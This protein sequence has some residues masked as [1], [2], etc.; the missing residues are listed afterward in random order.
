MRCLALASFC[1]FG[2]ISASFAGDIATPFSLTQQ[3]ALSGFPGY[4]A[5]RYYN[6]PNIPATYGSTATVIANRPLFLPMVFPETVTISSISAK[7]STVSSGG[8]FAFAIYAADPTTKKPT[9][10]SLA[11]T[12]DMST[13]T[14]GTVTAAMSYQFLA[15]T[16]YWLA[17]NVDNATATFLQATIVGTQYLS[18]IGGQAVSIGSTETQVLLIGTQAYGTWPDTT[19]TTFSDSASGMPLVNFLV[20]SSP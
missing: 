16:P 3:R 14:T 7:I 10:L 20:A 8:K 15:G 2:A 11:S 9:G 4:A 13:T 17:F 19:S 18:M 6:P 5:G 12:G 1:L